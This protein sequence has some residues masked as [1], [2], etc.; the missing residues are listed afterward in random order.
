MVDFEKIVDSFKKGTFETDFK[1]MVLI[2]NKIGGVRFEGKGYVRQSENRLLNFRLYASK[3][4]TIQA[5]YSAHENQDSTPGKL[6]LEDRYYDL[7]LVGYDDTRWKAHHVFPNIDL[8]LSDNDILVSGKLDNLSMDMPY[9]YPESYLKIHFFSCYEIPL[10]RMTTTEIQGN[11]NMVLDTA[12]FE[13]SEANFKVRSY[14]DDTIFEVRSQVSF[15]EAFHLRVQ[16]ALQYLTGKSVNWQAYIKVEKNNFCMELSIPFQKSICTYFEPPIIGGSKVFYENG[17][18]LFACFLA[19]VIEKTEKTQW[20]PVAYHLHNAC[21]STANSIDSRAISYS[22]AVEAIAS[23]IIIEQN[24]DK[25]N[26]VREFQK[27]MRKYIKTQTAFSDLESRMKTLIDMLGQARVQDKLHFLADNGHVER[28][29]IK[30]WTNLRN[31]HA[32]PT[33]KD[34]KKID[35]TNA[36]ELITSLHRVSVLLHQI[37]FYLIGYNGPFTDYGVIK[38]PT[39]QYPLTVA[40]N[41]P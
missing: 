2:Q 26:H 37:T 20:N 35:A 15:P 25:T 41:P 39:K 17:W 27:N 3:Q 7:I 13:A 22:V 6:I 21:E 10:N 19:Y 30:D 24:T 16:E 40:A 1:E 12:E 29:Y 14:D 32:H 23:L 31:R 9:N 34:L 18:R 8:N 33:L 5:S 28:A 4:E 38:F 36:Q 11:K